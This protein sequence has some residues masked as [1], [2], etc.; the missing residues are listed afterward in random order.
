[1]DNISAL[2]DSIAKFMW[3]L[4]VIVLIVSFR[5]SIQALIDSGRSR[6]FNI[7]IG[8]MEVGM[9]EVSK[10]QGDMI[11]DLQTQ[12]TNLQKDIEAIQAHPAGEERGGAVA[13]AAPA[14]PVP[15]KVNYLLW[16]DD[17]PSNNAFL[18][19]SLLKKGVRITTALTTREGM[20][21]FQHGNFDA[22]IS[23]MGRKENMLFIPTAGVELIRSIRNINKAVPIYIYSAI[24]SADLIEQAKQAGAN[25]V[26]N[27]PTVILRALGQ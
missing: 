19:D 13:F 17:N 11:K 20:E 25:Q 14:E 26:T 5:K 15:S 4:I 9:D 7:K 8:E 21:K 18:I 16:V 1:M 2:I 12:V 23:D 3:P 27:S 6:K 10:Q 22:V 24:S